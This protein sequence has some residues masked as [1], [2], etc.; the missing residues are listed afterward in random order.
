M[1]RSWM[2]GPKVL[3]VLGATLVACGSSNSAPS[4]D[5]GSDGHRDGGRDSGHVTSHDAGKDGAKTTSDANDAGPSGPIARF[6]LAGATVPNYLDVPFPSD[7]YL[8]SGKIIDPVP[9]M[10]AFVTNQTQFVTHELGKLN[11]FSRVALTELLVDDSSEAG[12]I[13]TLDPTTFPASEAACVA[14]TSSVF[15]LDLSATGAAARIPCRAQ[16]RDDRPY[17]TV[18]FQP[19]VAVGPGRGVVLQEGHQYATVVTSRI[20]TMGGVKIGASTDFLAVANGKSA[21][22]LYKT[23]FATAKGLLSSALATD[24]ATIVD[25]APYTTGSETKVLFQ[26]R[27]SLESVTVPTLAWD[28]ASLG[29]M[30]AKAFCAASTLLCATSALRTANNFADTIDDYLGTA[31]VHLS[32]GTDDPNADLPVR[33]HD[34]IAAI[35]TG[36]FQAQN[37]LSPSNGYTALDDATLSF[38]AS[39]N[40]IPNS[41]KPTVPIWV[42]LFV[43]TAAMPANGYPVVIVQHGLGESRAD[44]A[45]NLANVFC[46]AG[47]MVAAIDS[48]TFGARAVEGKYQVDKV[49]NFASG[50]GTYA[51]PD[52]LADTVNG[53]T[54][55]PNDFFGELLDF[56]AIRD[57]LRQ[58]EID[59]SQLARVLASSPNLAP[60]TTGMIVPKIDGTKIA[61]FGNSLG[62]IE[63]AAA[64]AIEPLIQSWVLNVAGGAVVLEVATHA[65]VI[66][67]FDLPAAGAGFGAGTDHLTEFHPLINLLQAAIDPGDPIGFAPYVVASPGTVNGTALTPKNV[68]QIEVVYDD[69]VANEGNEALARGLGLGLAVPNVGTN[70]GVQ[71]MAMVKDPTTIPDRLP[72]PSDNPDDAGLIHDTPKAGTTAVLVQTMPAQHGVNFQNALDTESYAIPYNQFATKTPF[73]KLGA[74][75]ATADPPFKVTSAYLA[76]QAMAVRFLTDSFAGKVPNVTGVP[77]PVRDYDQDGY[78]DAIDAD[79]NNPNVH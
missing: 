11:G 47:W 28:Q 65:P 32:D 79:P 21:S 57:Q 5:A 48:V 2:S 77:T 56:G 53:S 4:G 29:A 41:A 15:L 67:G 27:T 62:A 43:P 8:T 13:A 69:Y 20:K 71:T 44:E 78:P 19:S 7:V 40:V 9:G 66:A 46:K 14:D 36:V 68:L 39:G 61:Y 38:D 18:G 25:L 23:A 72:L 10:S 76:E 34:Q 6:K 75:S 16:F 45:F 26:M 63:G 52:G 17:S 58:A 31:M 64:A 55:G 37:Y 30:G 3:C 51:G 70:S 12:G 49:N 60:L 33:A 73:V 35:G 24:G 54:N 42:T 22:T 1:L 59:T 74:G 50:G